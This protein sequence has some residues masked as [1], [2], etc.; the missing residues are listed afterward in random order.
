MITNYLLGAF[1]E[2]VKHKKEIVEAVPQNCITSQKT[3][4]PRFR[5]ENR[6]FPVTKQ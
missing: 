5:K 2:K 3:S 4:K 6:A 1:T